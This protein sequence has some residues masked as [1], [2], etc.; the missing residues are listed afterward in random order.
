MRMKLVL[1]LSL[2]IVFVC[3]GKSVVHA[4]A[5]ADL[6]PFVLP[7]DDASG[8]ITNLSHLNHIPAGKHGS[9]R[10]DENGHFQAGGEPIRFWGVNITSHSSFT[11][12]DNA[13][14]VAARLAKFGVNLVRFHHMDFGWSGLST[15]S[16]IDYPQGNSRNLNAENLARL[17]YVIHQLKQQGIYTNLNLL[18]SRFF[19]PADG[20]PDAVSQ[21]NWKERHVLGFFNQDFRDL[22][23][24][25]ARQLLSHTNPH[26]GLTYAE[27]P[28]IAMVEINNE[29]GIFQQYFSGAIDDWPDVFRR[30]LADHWNAWLRERYVGDGE[31]ETAWGAKTGTKVSDTLLRN[32][33]FISGSDHWNVEW[34]GGAAGTI[35]ADSSQGR[36]GVR[37]EVTT[38]G[39]ENWHAQLNQGSLS[40]TK[41][42]PYTLTFSARSGHEVNLGVALQQHHGNFRIIESRRYKLNDQWQEFEFQFYADGDDEN[43]RIIFN[44]FG[45]QSAVVH[46]ADVSFTTGGRV[47]M[48]SS[49]E[50]LKAGTLHLNRR[51]R[52]YP[53]ARS[54]DWSAFL[55]DLEYAYWRELRDYVKETLGFQGL[56]A[57]T[58][59]MNSPP[60]AQAL[61]DFADGH[62]Y[63]QHPVFPGKAWDPVNWRVGTESMVN[64]PHN[65]TL[66]S[67]ARQRLQGLPFTV[68][69]YQHASPNPFSSEGPLLVAAYGALQDWDGVMMFAYDAG[70]ND[71][72]DT[73]RV[74]N[75]FSMNAHPT[76]MAAMLAGALIFRRGDV[77][78]AEQE[79]A[80]PFNADS[81]LNILATKGTGW[82]VAN[83]SHLEVPRELALQHRLTL[84]LSGEQRPSTPLPTSEG[85]VYRADTGQLIWDVSR[86]D[87]GVVT[88]NSP[89]SKAVVGFI[90]DRSF[91]LDGVHISVGATRRDWTTVSIHAMDGRFDQPEHPAR[92]LVITT[93]MMENTDMPW[94]ETG[95]SVGSTWGKPPTRIEVI[96]ATLDLPFAAS[97]I[98]AWALNETGQRMSEM[99]V[100]ENTDHARLELG[101]A[102]TLWYEI[103]VR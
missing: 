76:K 83:A 72:W 42:T 43:M 65:T 57:G 35:R 4:E 87:K 25:Y 68:S 56:V 46:L 8:G 2:P 16:L 6:V 97:R 96:P 34:H 80:I 55:R 60:T 44:G 12:A 69:E 59:I 24:E 11:S 5:V 91:D 29:N 1:I 40:L 28:A 95:D 89:H 81:E 63:W 86:S 82:N 31:L 77:S 41:G 48:P 32:G 67:L 78:P 99:P 26:T 52:A 36:G 62:A 9:I 45:A 18:N 13:R 38:P 20:L 10:V 14:N 98:R 75:F 73:R 27:D 85:P 23:K 90:D 64:N 47:G 17:D 71:N 61:F 22:E 51:D 3:S 49:D 53:E 70:R 92:L 93:G 66:G 37:W 103:E 100:I 101:Q 50:S 21:M 39:V 30:Q 84:D 88:V 79:V 74:D 94:N 7:F 19:Y 33:D 58:A 15:A 102:P 54:R